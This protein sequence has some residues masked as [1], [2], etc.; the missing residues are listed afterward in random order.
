MR[1]SILAALTATALLAAPVAQ[2]APTCQDRAGVTTRCGA[3]NA[4]PVGWSLPADERAPS[5]GADPS[6]LQWLGLIAAVG[7]LLALFALLPAFDGWD[8]TE[9][10]EE[11][12][13]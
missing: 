6:P 5:E 1:R 13:G 8:R 12:G 11:G 3:V 4:M 7:G 10:D 2:A 9:G